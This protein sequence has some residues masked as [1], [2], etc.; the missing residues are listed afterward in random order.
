MYN[1]CKGLLNVREKNRIVK[2]WLCAV[3]GVGAGE[4]MTANWDHHPSQLSE[5]TAGSVTLSF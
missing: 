4:I 2:H 3:G 5:I 1:F